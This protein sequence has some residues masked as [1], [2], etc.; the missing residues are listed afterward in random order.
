MKAQIFHFTCIAITFYLN[1]N[2]ILLRSGNK[3]VTDGGDEQ[4]LVQA[5]YP[6]TAI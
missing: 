5:N 6:L 4:V 1:G 2:L 3:K